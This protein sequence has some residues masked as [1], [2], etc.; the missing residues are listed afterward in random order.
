MTV[1]WSPPV[2]EVGI[3][4]DARGDICR[5]VVPSSGPKASRRRL[6]MRERRSAPGSDGVRSALVAETVDVRFELCSPGRTR[7]GRREAGVSFSSTSELCW[8]S[9]DIRAWRKGSSERQLRATRGNTSVP[10]QLLFCFSLHDCLR[11]L[12]LYPFRCLLCFALLW[13]LS[14]SQEKLYVFADDD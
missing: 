3:S 8:S 7:V 12:F 6:P 10:Y 14:V 13:F 1:E 5:L 2:V 9:S 4:V 11:M